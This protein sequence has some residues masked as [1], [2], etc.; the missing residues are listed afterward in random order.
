MTGLYSKIYANATSTFT[1][2]YSSSF[3][4][5]FFIMF[6]AVKST[7]FSIILLYT[8]SL[9]DFSIGRFLKDNQ[10]FLSICYNVL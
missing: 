4:F 6:L 1:F 8:F 7:Y 3:C 10:S 5:F 2:V 9:S